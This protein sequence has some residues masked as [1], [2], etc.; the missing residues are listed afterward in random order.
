MESS[1]H[2]ETT[3]HGAWLRKH[4]RVV[5]QVCGSNGVGLQAQPVVKV[6]QVN[7]LA[8]LGERFG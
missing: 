4:G 3:A 1:I 8:A 5:V 6:L 7:S 2:V